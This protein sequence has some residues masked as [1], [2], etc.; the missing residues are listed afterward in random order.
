MSAAMA[1]PGVVC[2][3][4]MT[5]GE[6]LDGLI[7]GGGTLPPPVVCNSRLNLCERCHCSSFKAASYPGGCRVTA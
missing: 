4:E 3:T 5:K 2:P 1:L 7:V 6:D